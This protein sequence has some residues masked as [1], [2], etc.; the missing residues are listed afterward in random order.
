MSSYIKNVTICYLFIEVDNLI[1]NPKSATWK[2]II[3]KRQF[4]IGTSTDLFKMIPSRLFDEISRFKIIDYL[5]LKNIL[6]KGD[7]FRDPKGISISGFLKGSPADPQVAI[8]LVDF[9][10]DIQEYKLSLN[11]NLNIKRHIDG[12]MINRSYLF[13]N[14]FQ[15]QINNDE[16]F[17]QNMK[18]NERFIYTTSTLNQTTSNYRK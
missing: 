4:I 1:L 18:I 17:K 9:G 12:K 11:P 3:L 2:S 10:I 8:N 13:S 5:I 6:V 16:W 14:V 7:W 15:E